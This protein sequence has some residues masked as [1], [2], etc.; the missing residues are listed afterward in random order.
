MGVYQTVQPTVSAAVSVLLAIFLYDPVKRG[1]II[2]SDGFLFQKKQDVRLI[3]KKLAEESVQ[4]F[5]LKELAKKVLTT[6]RETLRSETSA[7]FIKEENDNEW[8][9]SNRVVDLTM[10]IG[11]KLQQSTSPKMAS[12]A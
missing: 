5:D 7:I 2:A 12:K 3:L 6:L 4:I 11:N 10:F 8:G 1:L 9:Y